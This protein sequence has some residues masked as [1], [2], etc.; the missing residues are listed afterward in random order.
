VGAALGHPLLPIFGL[1]AADVAQ[2]DTVV[3]TLLDALY[4]GFVIPGATTTVLQDWT[5]GRH[6]EVDDINGTVVAEGALLGVPTPVNA[7]VVE[8]AHRIERGELQPGADNVA[9]MQ[10]LGAH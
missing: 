9:L 5:K 7:A 10:R 2:P 4:R 1:T 6:S 8:V 3:D